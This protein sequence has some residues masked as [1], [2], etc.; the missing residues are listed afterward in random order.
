VV[1]AG[2]GCR[3]T[4]D[5]PAAVRAIVETLD[6][7]VVTSY[8]GKGVFPED[9]PRFMGVT[10]GSLPPGATLALEQA[11]V[12][13]ALG[14]D[15]DGVT[16]A[17][18]E[19]PFGGQLV[20]VN[21]D[22]DAIG[23]S[24]DPAVGIVADI[25]EAVTALNDRLADHTPPAARWRPDR[26]GAAI[27]DEYDRHLSDAGL[28]DD[29]PPLHTPAVLETVRRVTPDDAIVSVDVGGFRLWAMQV[30]EAYEA[31]DFIAAG[32]WAGMG[33][34]LPAAIG[35]K[36][37]RP[38]APVVCLS[39]DGGLLMCLQELATAAAEDLDIVLI[40]SNNEDYGIISKKSELRTSAGEHPFTWT[41]PSFVKIAEGFDW[42][43]EAVADA[44]GLETA[45][46]DA[47]ARDGPTLI[48][49][50]VPTEEQSAEDGSAFETSIDPAERFSVR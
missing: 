42:D 37:A 10:G 18:W 7:G 31:A 25:R 15:F 22:P 39:G 27:R 46:E 49:V 43:G 33:V 23:A 24:Y 45:V 12:V 16:T 34:G 28:L 29:G 14:T 17:G 2:G 3:R 36:L 44:E 35:A 26:V 9:D 30:F 8:K 1:Y 11:D 40:V 48:D 32:S 38:D 47:I 50:E 19:V 4:T 13:L 20:H 6:A 41:A 21:L 5:G